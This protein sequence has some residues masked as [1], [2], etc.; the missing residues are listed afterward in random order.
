MMTPEQ[1]EAI[2]ESNARAIQSNS[3]A[4]AQGRRQVEEMKNV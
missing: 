2:L 4:I 1:I 3:N